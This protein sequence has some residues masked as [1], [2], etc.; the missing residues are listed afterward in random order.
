MA[1]MD[2]ALVEYLGGP[3]D[4]M[5]DE[6]DADYGDICWIRKELRTDEGANVMVQAQYRRVNHARW[7]DVLLYEPLCYSW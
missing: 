2:K 3:F 7:G 6:T 5:G 1:P 4:G